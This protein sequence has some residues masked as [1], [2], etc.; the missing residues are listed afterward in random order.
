M[1]EQ[2]KSTCFIDSNIWLYAMITTVHPEEKHEKARK[3][4]SNKEEV[5][6]TSTQ[7]I[8]EVCVNLLKK[9]I[10]NEQQI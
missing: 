4:I 2:S 9:L 1:S 7:V 5:I 6:I 8:N 3:L 10:L